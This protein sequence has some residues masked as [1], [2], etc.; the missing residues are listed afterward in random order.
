MHVKDILDKIKSEQE[1]FSVDTKLQLI[2]MKVIRKIKSP[3][4]IDMTLRDITGSYPKFQIQIKEE[5]E[6]TKFEETFSKGDILQIKGIYHQEKNL[7]LITHTEK[8][9]EFNLEDYIKPMDINAEELFSHIENLIN[10]MNDPWLQKLLKK[11]FANDA[12]KHGFIDG[13]SAVKYHHAYQHGNLE[14]TVGMLTAF[15]N[16]Y[17]HFYDREG[18]SVDCDLVNAGII[19]QDI[20][21]LYEY[22]IHN[23]IPLYVKKY[24]LIGHSVLGSELIAKMI[25]TIPDFPEELELKIKHIILSHHGKRE[26]GSPVEPAFP[27]AR[28]VHAL[29]LLDARLKSIHK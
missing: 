19:L 5:E 7:I 22:N 6:L 12:I 25:Q 3:S 15:K 27:E 29:D 28:V 13:P 11:I 9:K 14:H 1:D 18:K 8:A 16:Y 26:W 24:G 2:E 10:D 4:L 23:G 20:G 21:K 17:L